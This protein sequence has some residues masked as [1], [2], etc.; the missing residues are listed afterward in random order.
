MSDSGPS[1]LP[2]F[3]TDFQDL[4]DNTRIR[5]VGCQAAVMT[6]L[7]FCNSSQFLPHAAT[8][9]LPV[10]TRPFEWHMPS[11]AN[12]LKCALR[13]RL[14]VLGRLHCPIAKDGMDAI[15]S[16]G[17]QNRV[18]I[19]DENAISPRN[20][21][22]SSF[23][24]HSSDAGD[25]HL[26][27]QSDDEVLLRPANSSSGSSKSFVPERVRFGLLWGLPDAELCNSWP[28]NALG[29]DFAMGPSVR[30]RWRT[31]SDEPSRRQCSQSR[32]G[33]S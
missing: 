16:I 12:Q 18:A 26:L 6:R 2:L 33:N 22:I 30:Q 8:R 13:T 20:L 23:P 14:S 15:G 10:P 3:F 17:I 1:A 27:I 4:Q 31:H 5:K 32:T 28:A 9:S 24:L 21:F 11:G 7:A 19:S 29:T 25:E